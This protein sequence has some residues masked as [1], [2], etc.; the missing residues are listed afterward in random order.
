MNIEEAHSA[1]PMAV[2]A[3]VPLNGDK[4]YGF[5]CVTAGTLTITR[6]NGVDALTAFPVSA[7]VYYP[8]PIYLGSVGGTAT[9]AG[10]ASGT[11]LK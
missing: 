2:N 5:L 4:V 8:I 9:L 3:S 10:G 6:L 7:G 11:L 1:H